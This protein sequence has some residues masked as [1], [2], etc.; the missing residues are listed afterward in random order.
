VAHDALF[1]DKIAGSPSVST[2]QYQIIGL[3]KN[4]KYY[5]RV[6]SKVD[7]EW[8]EFS[9]KQE[10][11]SLPGHSLILD[12]EDDYLTANSITSES[13][14]EATIECWVKLDGDAGN[15]AGGEADRNVIWSINTSTGG[16]HYVLLYHP[17]MEMLALWGA[18]LDIYDIKLGTEWHHIAVSL[19]NNEESYIYLDGKQIASFTQNSNAIET[20]CQFSI[21]QEWDGDTPSDF[22]KGEMD[23]FRI[24]DIA[25]T[26]EEIRANMNLSEPKG[27]NEHYIAHFTFDEVHL[28]SSSD[29]I[30]KDMSLQNNAT[31]VGGATIKNSE[32]V[33]LQ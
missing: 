7:G 19:R 26:E 13:S 18:S 21:G 6:Q 11:F 16:N 32:G 27:A 1:I 9:G 23:E 29:S 5:Y 24:W 30:I 20:G 10:F 12:G 15:S 2:N 22:Y 33:I 3:D 28:Q 17:H 4:S 8:S 25:L 14:E 31:L